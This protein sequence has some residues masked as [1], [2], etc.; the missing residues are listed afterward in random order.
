MCTPPDICHKEAISI[1]DHVLYQ[2]KMYPIIV[3]S[4]KI[5]N[6]LTKMWVT[7]E[8]V[9]TFLAPWKHILYTFLHVLYWLLDVIVIIMYSTDN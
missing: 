5:C 6:N 9:H 7:L 8:Q 1:L 2:H 4:C 3:V